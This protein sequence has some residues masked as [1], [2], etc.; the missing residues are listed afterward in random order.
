MFLMPLSVFFLASFLVLLFLLVSH[1]SFDDEWFIQTCSFS[2][3]PF[4]PCHE[5]RRTGLFV[6]GN[7]ILVCFSHC[8]CLPHHCSWTK[9]ESLTLLSCSLGCVSC[10]M[11][12]TQ[13]CRYIPL[14]PECLVIRITMPLYTSSSC[15]LSR[16]LVSR[17]SSISSFLEIELSKTKS[18]LSSSIYHINT[19]AIQLQSILSFFCFLNTIT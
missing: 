3:D 4:L 6:L 5:A 16:T 1:G 11:M 12:R 14:R 7:G 18:S 10:S 13:E 8:S 2:S 15:Y 17:K 9:C 19:C